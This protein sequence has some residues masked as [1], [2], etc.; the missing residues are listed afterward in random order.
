MNF[1]MR[2]CIHHNHL[3]SF[4]SNP[5]HSYWNM[6]HYIHQSSCSYIP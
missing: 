3:Y 5:Y 1:Y 4:L 2:L 6:S